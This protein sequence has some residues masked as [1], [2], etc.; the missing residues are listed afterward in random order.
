[1]PGV[2]AEE[3]RHDQEQEAAFRKSGIQE[4][5]S[6]LQQAYPPQGNS[7]SDPLMDKG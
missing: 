2:Q 6:F 4:I 7:V 3:L 5:L 1:M